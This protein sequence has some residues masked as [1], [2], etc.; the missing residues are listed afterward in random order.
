VP[1]ESTKRFEVTAIDPSGTIRESPTPK[2]RVSGKELITGLSFSHIVELLATQEPPKRSFYEAEC[3]RG[4]WSVRE[5]KRQ[6]ASLYFERSGLSKD[7]AKLAELA[8]AAVKVALAVHQFGRH[9]AIGAISG[10]G[11][12]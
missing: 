11:W 9:Q 7:K 10:S 3:L 6:V 4:S 5:R 12:E 8:R 2:S 1:P